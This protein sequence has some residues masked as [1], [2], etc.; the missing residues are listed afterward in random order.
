MA[1]EVMNY[2]SREYE[3]SRVL[4]LTGNLTVNTITAFTGMV[5]SITDK[6]SVMINMENV[7]VITSAGLQALIE[8][9]FV[10][11]EKERRVVIL[12]PGDELMNLAEAMGVYHNL[13]FAQSLEEGSTKIRY[14]T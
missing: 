11:K 8:I 9:S 13:I 7:G 1:Q 3:G 4:D 10:A 5:N 2:S 6:E 14:F 12:W